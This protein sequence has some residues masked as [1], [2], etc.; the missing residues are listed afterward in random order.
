[1]DENRFVGI[2]A[3]G[4]RSDPRE[5]VFEGMLFWKHALMQDARHENS[6]SQAP[7]KQLMAPFF[8]ATQSR[9]NPIAAPAKRRIACEQPHARPGSGLPE[10]HPRF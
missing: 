1:M 9:T 5:I 10:P 2:S 3:T 4:M 7:V 8:K 6:I